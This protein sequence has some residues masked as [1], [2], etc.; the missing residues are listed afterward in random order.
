MISDDGYALPG[1][2]Q[3][4]FTR[5]ELNL[6]RDACELSLQSYD[7]ENWTDEFIENMN[8]KFLDDEFKRFSGKSKVKTDDELTNIYIMID[9]NTGYYKIGRSKNPTKRESTLQSEKPTI[10]LLCSYPATNKQELEIHNN[11]KDFRVR[12]EWF[13][14]ERWQVE[15]IAKQLRINAEKK[16]RGLL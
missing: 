16:R 14:L 5:E 4:L 2:A 12:G 8:Q 9:H 6:M 7:E 10:E 11:Y 3:Y 13:N 1:N 15:D